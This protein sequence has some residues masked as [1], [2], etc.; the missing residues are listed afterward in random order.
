MLEVNVNYLIFFVF[1][2]LGYI[3]L[4]FSRKFK[5]AEPLILFLFGLLMQYF[6]DIEF[7][8]II[9]ICLMVLAFDVGAHFIPYKFKHHDFKIGEFILLSWV[10]Y[11]FVFWIIISL[12]WYFRTW[13][14]NLM[15]AIFLSSVLV[16][17]SQFEILKSFKVKHN[18]L[19]YLTELEDNLSNSFMMI[20]GLVL[21]VFMNKIESL[22]ILASILDSLKIIFIDFASGLFLGLVMLFIIV[23]I[24]KRKFTHYLTFIFAILVYYISIHFGGSGFI[25]VFVCSIFYHNVN[26]KEASMSEF[27]PFVSNLI[28]VLTFLFLG[29][30][31][32]VDNNVLSLSIILF[33]FYLFIRYIILKIMFRYTQNFV[34]FDCPKGLATGALLLFAYKSISWC[35]GIKEIQLF[36]ILIMFFVWCNLLAYYLN[37]HTHKITN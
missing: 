10:I 35:C 21:L 33:L 20:L 4:S 8:T 29:Y 22:N 18:R 31:I 14:F 12:V 23:K 6:V 11:S 7:F 13:Y 36:S 26:S 2:I 16:A 24:F 17:C 5:L 27:K 9:K 37:L 34:A 30:F 3:T 25:A 28:Y 1:V 19:Y 32:Y 15:F